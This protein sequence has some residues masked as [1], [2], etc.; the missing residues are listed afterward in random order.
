MVKTAVRAGVLF[1]E[2]SEEAKK[3]AEKVVENLRERGLT[4]GCLK[5][6]AFCPGAEA[7]EE[8]DWGT[9]LDLAVALGGD[10]TLLR[11][12]QLIKAPDVPVIGV[13]LGGLGFLTEVRPE[14][15]FQV[16]DDVFLGQARVLERMMIEGR[17]TGENGTQSFRALNEIAITCEGMPRV[18]D[19]NTQING[20]FVT[21]FRADGLLVSTPT[22]S[23]AYCMAAGGPIVHRAMRCL[24]LTPICPHTLTSRPLVIPDTSRISI[25]LNQNTKDV[26]LAADSQKSWPLHPGL[27]VELSAAARGLSLVCAPNRNFYDILRTKLRWGER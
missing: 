17:I 5:S 20:H 6:Q 24:I 22:G 2:G 27:T 13:K 8:E 23:T 21:D 11:A 26:Y 25:T 1:R 9:G 12:A 19:L 18:S 3:L 15:L 16:L 10:G 4:V 7:V 14:E